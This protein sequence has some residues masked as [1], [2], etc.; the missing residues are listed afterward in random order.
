MSSEAPRTRGR[1]DLAVLG[2]AALVVVLADQVSKSL[3]VSALALG[4]RVDVVGDL[5]VLW[6]V[7]NSGS[8]FSLF[9]FPGNQLLFYAVTIV[10]VGMVVWFHRAYAGRGMWLQLLLGVFLGGTLGNLIDRLRFGAVT[11]FISVGFGDSR[12]PTWNVADAS[13]TVSLFVLLGYIVFFDRHP[14]EETA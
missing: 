1:T 10:A 11:D 7:E 5:V 12:F 9:R 3:V 14:T 8:S 6:R 13:L 4:Q 2:L